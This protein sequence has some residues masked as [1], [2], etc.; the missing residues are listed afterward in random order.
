MLHWTKV[1]LITSIIA[2]CLIIESTQ[3]NKLLPDLVSVRITISRPFFTSNRPFICE[4]FGWKPNI[5]SI[6]LS[7]S[8]NLGRSRFFSLP[9]P[10]TYFELGV[11]S[12]LRAREKESLDDPILIFNLYLI[13]VQ[14][15]YRC[16]I[17]PKDHLFLYLIVLVK[18][19][20]HLL[21]CY[22]RL[23]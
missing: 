22:W 10:S 17:N 14:L 2:F 8:L 6:I 20:S 13:L 1:G 18:R 11:L 7:A 12:L 16:Q 3:N 15:Y 9:A 23:W 21:C 4:K 19:A 5:A